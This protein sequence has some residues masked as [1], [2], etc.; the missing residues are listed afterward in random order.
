MKTY[1][2]DTVVVGSGAAGFAAADRLWSLGRTSIAVVTEHVKLG[3]SRNAGSDKQTY[4]KL[5]LSG[6]EPDSVM[7]MAETLF[8]G[9]CVDGDHALCEAALSTRSFMRL[10]ELGVPF[11]CNRYGEYVGYKTDHDP[12]CRATSAG[13]YTS[14]M[15]TEALER[16]VRDRQGPILDRFQ[17]IRILKLK[18]CVSGLLCLDLEAAARNENDPYVA[19]QCQNLVWATG[20]PA[21]IYA[22]SVY[23]HGQNGATGI[24]LEAG[25]L[26]KNLTEWQYGMASLKPRWNVSGTYMQA[27]PRIYS[28]DE[29]GNEYDFLSEYFGNR[30]EMLSNVFLKGYQW[31][32][33]IR[34]VEGGSSI[35]DILVFLETKKG[36]RVWL[37]YRKNPFEEVD[38][39]RLS[40]EAFQ[41]LDNAGAC[42]GTPIERLRHMNLPAVQFYLDHNVDLATEPLEIAVCAQHNNGGLSVDC[43]WQTQ[44]P[45]LFAIGECSAT[46]GV[47]RPG[48]TA[49]NAGQVGALRAAQHISS[50]VPREPFPDDVWLLEIQPQISEFLLPIDFSQ[51]IS[52]AMLQEKVTNARRRMSLAGAAFRSPDT[53]KESLKAAQKELSAFQGGTTVQKTDGLRIAYQYR[54]LLIAQIVYLSAMIDYSEA[55]RQSRG[56]ALYYDPA[57]KKPSGNLPET[58]R[59]S[60]TRNLVG[61]HIQEIAWNGGCTIA[62]WRAPRPIPQQDSFF[63]NIWRSFRKDRNIH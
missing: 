8:Q 36:R 56:S 52:S 50:T 28:T 45:G 7:E 37:D 55:G 47:Y 59:Y 35:V 12:R 22:D 21:G 13:P 11:P 46:H 15:M 60:V 29:K 30:Y 58:I 62:S 51:G 3:T 16:S 24:A 19:I 14:K 57:G 49:L 4:Y 1:Q 40:L 63:E 17:A 43:W 41:Y 26:G 27:L 34:K 44:V 53:M 9:G 25:A 5:T 23:P 39:T 38:F 48:G 2:F 10:V 31:P 6:S 18:G 54:S 61:E 42:F 33:D 20:G 32:F